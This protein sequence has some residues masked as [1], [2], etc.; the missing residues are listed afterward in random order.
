MPCLL[1]AQY[2]LRIRNGNKK[3]PI[4]HSIGAFYLRLNEQPQIDALSINYLE[5][6]TMRFMSV[7]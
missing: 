6:S 3:A 7:M 1:V 2:I 4:D 5:A